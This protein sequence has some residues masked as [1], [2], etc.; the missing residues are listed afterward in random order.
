MGLAVWCDLEEGGHAFDERQLITVTWKDDWRYFCQRHCKIAFVTAFD[1]ARAEGQSDISLPTLRA[2]FTIRPSADDQAGED[3]P[4]QEPD[5]TQTPCQEPQDEKLHSAKAPQDAPKR[6]SP[7]AIR[8][9]KALLE[10]LEAG[11]DGGPHA[12]ERLQGVTMAWCDAK[13][14][15]HAFDGREV[16]TVTQQGGK[17]AFC[18]AHCI[19]ALASVFHAARAAGEAKISGTALGGPLT[20]TPGENQPQPDSKPQNGQARSGECPTSVTRG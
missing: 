2:S 19:S 6:A 3:K 4:G 12:D 9:A 18:A 8:E 7:R 13:D 10:I 5:G 17:R 1:R 20:I 14:K 15:G 16:I 11:P